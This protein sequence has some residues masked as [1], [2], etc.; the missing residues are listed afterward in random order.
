MVYKLEKVSDFEFV[1]KKRGKM[2]TNAKFF[3]SDF[4]VKNINQETIRQLVNVA[5]LPGIKGD[6]LAMADAHQG[7]GFPIGGVGAFDLDSGVI[8]PGGIGFDINCGMSLV[9]TNLNSTDLKRK[10]FEKIMNK[11]FCS[12]PKGK[13]N[14]NFV[15]FTKSELIDVISEGSD[16]SKSIGLIGNKDLVRI[17]D[18][19]KMDF[20]GFGK[21]SDKAFGRGINQLGSLGSGNHFIAFGVAKKEGIHNLK[22]AKKFGF[23]FENQIYFLVHSGSRGFGHQIVK[24]YLL[25][26]NERAKELNIKFSDMDLNYLLFNERV[27]EQYF[28]AMKG[29]AN[30]G[31]VN[32]QLLINE[33]NYV[34]SK[35][36][37]GFESNLVYDVC[38]NVAKIESHKLAGKNKEL[39]IHRKGATRSFG[40]SYKYLPSFFEKTGL[41]VVVGGSM[42]TGF[43]LLQGTD[44]A[45]EKSFGSTCH[46]SGRAISRSDAMNRN[47]I[48]KFDVVKEMMKKDIIVKVE[49]EQYAVQEAGFAYKDL[50]KVLSVVEKSGLSKRVLDFSPLGTIIS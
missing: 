24:D 35:E 17:E 8:S 28:D 9:K 10:D 48:H 47:R 40:P 2:N 50:D 18:N 44:I 43:S 21:I 1:V 23:D 22:V 36:I 31:F 25:K 6:A 19:G 7:F 42:E 49:E 15:R 5:S 14:N 38:H 41:P 3:S 20:D 34:L 26:F 37:K 16:W 4:L 11:I 45:L 13:G 12:I 27:S 33:V 29:A 30:F 46:G 32:R 39:L